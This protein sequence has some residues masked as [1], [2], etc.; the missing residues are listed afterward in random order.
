MLEIPDKTSGLFESLLGAGIFFIPNFLLLLEIMRESF[1]I[2][3]I[4][5]YIIFFLLISTIANLKF[6][7]KYKGG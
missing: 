2:F 7:N 6:N 1:Y 4:Y 5:N 3:L